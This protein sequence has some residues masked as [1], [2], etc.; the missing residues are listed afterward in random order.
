[1]WLSTLIFSVNPNK[2]PLVE[3]ETQLCRS[4]TWISAAEV[5]DDDDLLCFVLASPP[6]SSVTGGK[7]V[8]GPGL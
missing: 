7:K 6:L 3:G 1:L 8:I 5:L 2:K 4:P